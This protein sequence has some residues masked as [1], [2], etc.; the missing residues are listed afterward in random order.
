VLDDGVDLRPELRVTFDE[1]NERRGV[2]RQTADARRDVGRILGC[3]DA[4]IGGRF[5]RLARV[6]ELR[7]LRRLSHRFGDPR[8]AA[9]TSLPTGRAVSRSTL[10]KVAHETVFELCPGLGHQ[11]LT[12]AFALR[13]S[14]LQDQGFGL[15]RLP[16][17]SRLDHPRAPETIESQKR[18]VGDR[19]AA[20]WS[21]RWL[22]PKWDPIAERFEMKL[23]HRSRAPVVERLPALPALPSEPLSI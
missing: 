12:Q 18:P 8:K 21:N 17:C 5:P 1:V 16:V 20:A 13:R 6:E 23:E 7:L 3:G 2:Y 9:Q 11:A 19:R 15:L 22:A 10:G 14:E 4:P